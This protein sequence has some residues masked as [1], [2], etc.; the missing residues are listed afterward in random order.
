MTPQERDAEVTLNPLP[1]GGARHVVLDYIRANFEDP[2]S[3]KDLE[4]TSTELIKNSNGQTGWSDSVLGQC[5]KRIRRVQ[6]VEKDIRF[7]TRTDKLRSACEPHDNPKGRLFSPKQCGLL[8]VEDHYPLDIVRKLCRITVRPV[9]V[10]KSPKRSPRIIA[11]QVQSIHA[12]FGRISCRT[13]HWEQ[14][15]QR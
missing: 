12:S 13:S 7:F 8:P 9:P 5:Q 1:A 6:L 15:R 14:T 2:D 11:P 10:S 3:I 4:I